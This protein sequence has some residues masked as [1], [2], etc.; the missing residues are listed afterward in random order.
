MIRLVVM[1]FDWAS[2]DSHRFVT[3]DRRTTDVSTLSRHFVSVHLAET[4]DLLHWTCSKLTTTI[5][6]TYAARSSPEVTTILCFG[7]TSLEA[8]P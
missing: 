7:L 4:I 3:D 6:P 2:S 8:G 5:L 1:P